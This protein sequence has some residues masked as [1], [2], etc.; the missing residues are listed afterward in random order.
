MEELEGCKTK[1][2]LVGKQL[3]EVEGKLKAAEEASIGKEEV[4]KL[5]AKLYEGEE[6]GQ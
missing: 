3:K 4:E 2:K 6:R 1:S 5:S